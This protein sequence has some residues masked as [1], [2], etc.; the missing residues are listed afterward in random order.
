MSLNQGLSLLV[1]VSIILSACFWALDFIITGLRY[2]AWWQQ[3]EYRFDRMRVFSETAEGKRAMQPAYYRL[4]IFAIFGTLAIWLVILV[5]SVL[6]PNPSSLT[7]IYIGA[8][9]V[10]QLGVMAIWIKELH[11]CYRSWQQHRL[12]HPVPTF[13]AVLLS[14]LGIGIPLVYALGVF[15]LVALIFGSALGFSPAD[16]ILGELGWMVA[17]YVPSFTVV[18]FFSFI[19]FGL[20]LVIFDLLLPM[21]L[22]VC[23]LPLYPLTWLLKQ[24]RVRIA[25]RKVASCKDLTIIGITGS[26]GK[27]STKEFLA[28]ILATRYKVCKTPEHTNTELGMVQVVEQEL[29]NEHEVFVVEMG[30]YKRGEIRAMCRITPP[31]IAIVT[32]IN[33]QHQA[34]FG[35]IEGT[36]QAKYELIEAL[37]PSLPSPLKRGREVGVAVFNAD[38]EHCREMARRFDG[39]KVYYST[40]GN[41]QIDGNKSVVMALNIKPS[42]DRVEFDICVNQLGVWEPQQTP[43][44]GKQ[45]L[46]DSMQHVELPFP[47]VQVVSNFL[48]ATTVALKMGIALETIADVAR[49]LRP[50]PGAMMPYAGIN[51]AYIVDDSYSSNPDGFVAALD[52]LDVVKHA[53]ASRSRVVVVTSGMI[54]LGEA[55]REAYMRVG[56]KLNQTADV[57]VV[58]KEGVV[59]R[60]GLNDT[61][62]TRCEIEPR[63]VIELL[64]SEMSAETVVLLEGRMPETILEAIKLTIDN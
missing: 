1:F 58:T 6:I 64:Q 3:K 8:L 4:R 38:N 5:L 37:S 42:R 22:Y 12:S 7:W 16:R 26:Y 10:A 44:T 53:N 17:L 35:S 39:T 14:I 2:I 52:Y 28:S 9:V 55:E 19:A 32:G 13:K 54:E 18:A 48:A 63:T 50:R 60:F 30:A 49:E 56:A 43:M 61:V 36:M 45:K 29:T 41:M 31:Q 34:L 47:G 15:V 23:I 62:M 46:S 21:W 24:Q 25:R 27:T 57:V 51:G 11:D 59:D 33:E 20:F 40:R